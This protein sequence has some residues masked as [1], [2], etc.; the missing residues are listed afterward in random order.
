M[1]YKGL[2]LY[3]YHPSYCEGENILLLT[4][5]PSQKEVDRREADGWSVGIYAPPESSDYEFARES[6]RMVLR[7]RGTLPPKGAI[8]P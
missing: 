1:K 7:A 2:H 6:L 5:S 4:V 8:T 3:G